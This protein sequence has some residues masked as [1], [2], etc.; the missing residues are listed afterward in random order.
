ML[1]LPPDALVALHKAE[2]G[3]K[4]DRFRILNP[5]PPF[6]RLNGHG[7]IVV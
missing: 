1:H 7:Y 2:Q 5:A 3:N 6:R 4:A